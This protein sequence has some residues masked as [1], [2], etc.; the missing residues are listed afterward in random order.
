MCLLTEGIQALNSKDEQ[1]KITRVGINEG[2]SKFVLLDYWQHLREGKNLFCLLKAS[3][4]GP[5]MLTEKSEEDGV[6][7]LYRVF[8]KE[9]DAQTYASYICNK[10]KIDTKDVRIWNVDAEKLALTLAK[11]S[12]K[13]ACNGEG[14]YK[15]YAMAEDNGLL[16]KIEVFWSAFSG[17]L[18]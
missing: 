2:I 17:D 5:A 14:V 11:Q 4:E 12:L 10:I 15:C 16:K 7:G 9:A 1:Q 3:P 18:N 6:A 8:Y 13:K